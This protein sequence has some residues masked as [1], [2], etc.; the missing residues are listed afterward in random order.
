MAH[1]SRCWTPHIDLDPSHQIKVN[2]LKLAE[3]CEKAGT[4]TLKLPLGVVLE[5]LGLQDQ[6]Q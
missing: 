5:S 6:S 2:L 4:M 1:F 3:I